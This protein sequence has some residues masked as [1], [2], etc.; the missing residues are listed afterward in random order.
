MLAAGSIV[1]AYFAFFTGYSDIFQF[2]EAISG[3]SKGVEKSKLIDVNEDDNVINR[4]G[5][6]RYILRRVIEQPEYFTLRNFEGRYFALDT[7]VPFSRM[8]LLLI[9]KLGTEWRE[10]A[11]GS[12]GRFSVE[13]FDIDPKG[14]YLIF[15]NRYTSQV[16]D[17]EDGYGRQFNVGFSSC[18][19]W[20]VS[21]EISKVEISEQASQL[22]IGYEFRTDCSKFTANRKTITTYTGLFYSE[23]IFQFRVIFDKELNRSDIV[24]VS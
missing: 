4:Y 13:Y 24:R 7:G 9:G 2:S 17:V 1:I 12:F 3:F 19:G 22:W 5:N 20:G 15:G 14:R 11:I 18:S 16:V 8:R 10:I 23:Q 21:V 6:S